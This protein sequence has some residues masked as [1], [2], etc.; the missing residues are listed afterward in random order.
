MEREKLPNEPP[1]GEPLPHPLG[2]ASR[3]PTLVVILGRWTPSTIE[4]LVKL[5]K[6]VTRIRSVDLV[7]VTPFAHPGVPADSLAG[8]RLKIVLDP[9]DVL[10]GRYRT[11]WAPRVYLLDRLGNLRWIQPHAGYT[12]ERLLASVLERIDEGGGAPE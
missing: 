9:G 12:V 6:A 10:A 7:A 11:T 5:H 3:R 4:L 2:T 1:L 8:L